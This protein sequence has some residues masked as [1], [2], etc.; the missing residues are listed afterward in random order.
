MR[1]LHLVLILSLSMAQGIAR[2]YTCYEYI[3]GNYQDS[4]SHQI[5]LD[6]YTPTSDHLKDQCISAFKALLKKYKCPLIKIKQKIKC[7]TALKG[8]NTTRIC[9][10][11]TK[12]GY[13]LFS[14]DFLDNINIIYNRWD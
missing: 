5:T 2:E 8:V 7:G 3:S 14:K 9:Y 11:E 12:E 6:E 4:F 13:Y 1:K 10:L